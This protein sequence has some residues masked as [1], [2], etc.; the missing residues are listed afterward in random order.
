VGL[1]LEWL[2]FPFDDPTRRVDLHELRPVLDALDGRLPCHSAL[3][4]EPGG[5][6]EISTRP[7]DAVSDA[8]DAARTD[9]ARLRDAL[10]G[11]GVELV[12]RGLDCHRAPAR[13]VDTARYRAMEA[14]FDHAG[15]DGRTMMC[16]SA[17][18]QINVDFDGD[19][20]D[21]WRAAHVVAGSLHARGSTPAPNRLDVWS[22]IDATRTAA[23]GG[24]DPRTAWPAYAFDA[25][26][27][28]IRIGPDDCEPVLGHF[29][30][31][32]W[33]E[34]GHPLGWPTEADLREHL[35]TLFPPVRPRG[36]LEIRTLDACADDEWPA[37][38]EHAIGLLLDGPGRDEILERA[39]R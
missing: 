20:R 15:V 4:V 30:F 26:V 24:T 36:F 29:R 37:L 21:A 32:D 22:R 6:L 35:T 3:S 34:H 28:F 2:T 18:I 16:N 39:C 27:M 10:A 1:E 25:R 7:F 19:V 9:A 5:Q 14:Y 31:R 33:I 12:G 17:S 13:V 8:I 11:I 23:V 38:A